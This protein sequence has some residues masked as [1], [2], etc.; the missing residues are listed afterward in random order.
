MTSK[1]RLYF[2]LG[3]PYAY[4]ATTRAAAVLGVAPELEPVL[5]GAIFQ[6]R[7]SGSWSQTP[8]RDRHVAEIE[9]RAGAYGLPPVAWPPGWPVGGLPAMRAATWAK[10]RGAVD[11]FTHAAY[12]R[13][14]VRGQDVSDV[15][16][17]AAAAQDAGLDADAMREAIGTDAIKRRLRQA[18]E[19][20]WDAG[21]RG[22]PTLAVG[23]R[24]F[25]GDDR[26]EAAA[27][28]V[29]P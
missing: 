12:R 16:T 14:F 28:L 17:L 7:G 21:V 22:V 4:L 9:R 1:P 23:R 18:T 5:L 27:R 11:A 29:A 13:A 6:R 15:D 10:E 19:A 3:S 2:D 8:E 26:L 24:L 20:A 25:Y